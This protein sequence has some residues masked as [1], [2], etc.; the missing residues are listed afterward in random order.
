MIF[1]RGLVLLFEQ[2]PL[3]YSV[4]QSISSLL[5]LQDIFNLLL[6]PTCPLRLLAGKP[7]N[8]RALL[9]LPAEPVSSAGPRS[10]P[11]LTARV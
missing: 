4:M 9:R 11:G 1:L 8:R 10:V 6:S 2:A 7:A 5:I 3:K